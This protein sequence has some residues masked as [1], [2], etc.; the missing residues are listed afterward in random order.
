MARVIKLS[1]INERL[2][3]IKLTWETQVTPSQ[4]KVVDQ[5]EK[6]SLR[7]HWAERRLLS[8]V[9]ELVKIPAIVA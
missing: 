2:A 1:H 5:T 3:N 4:N 8:E 9:A 7:F 6:Q